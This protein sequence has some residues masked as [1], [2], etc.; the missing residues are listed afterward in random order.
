MT[1][2]S[3]LCFWTIP[4]CC[5]L[6]AV[7][8]PRTLAVGLPVIN[9]YCFCQ[10]ACIIRNALHALRTRGCYVQWVLNDGLTLRHSR[11]AQL[12]FYIMPSV[13]IQSSHRC[14]VSDYQLMYLLHLKQKGLFHKDYGL[15]K[16]SLR[17]CTMILACSD[18]THFKVTECSVRHWLNCWCD[19]SSCGLMPVLSLK[20]HFCFKE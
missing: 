16:T 20:I 18:L 5:Y 1:S 11:Q 7:A 10:Y 17:G 19:S 4:P 6:L 13:H 3:P 12:V 9:G 15:P 14:F 2:F 8:C